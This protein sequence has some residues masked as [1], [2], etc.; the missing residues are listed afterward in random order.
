VLVSLA[1]G[2]TALGLVASVSL[3]QAQQQPLAPSRPELA[4]G[5][6]R[7][8]RLC[9]GRAEPGGVQPFFRTELYFGS[10]KP[11][12]S[13]VTP[14]EFQRF[15]DAEVTPRFP[16]GLTMITGQGQFRGSNGTVQKERSVLLI[17]LYPTQTGR[18]SGQKIEQ[19]R[20]AYERAFQQESV[21]R[22]DEP[23]AECV[24]F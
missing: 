6:D 18:A 8:E 3:A 2:A 21:L 9:G 5:W 14:E 15:I 10:N 24:S 22:A 7:D 1:A 16:D 4:P 20:T 13:V 23:Q 12:G 11:D 17:L 19:I